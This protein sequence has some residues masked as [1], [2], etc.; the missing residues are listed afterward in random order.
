VTF[1]AEDPDGATDSDDATFTVTAVNDPPQITALSEMVFNE[2]D[3]LV[4]IID[5]LYKYVED[6]DHP[7]SL[8]IITVKAGQNVIAYVD[9]PNVV[10]KAPANWYGADTLEVK[11]SDGELADSVKVAVMVKSINDVPYFTG[12]PDTVSFD[13]ESDTTITM[14]QFAKDVDAN[15]NLSWSFEASATELNIDFDSGLEELTLS[16]PGYVGVVTLRCMVTDDSSTSAVDSFYV[17]ISLPTAIED[18]V[19]IIPLEYNLDQN[20]PNPFNP[21]THIQFGMKKAGDVKI[22]VYN[23]L[24]QKVMTLYD[25]YKDAGYHI[26]KFNASGF[27][28]GLY[29]YRMET[30]E[31]TSIKKMILMK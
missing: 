3:S 26:V 29:F 10:I 31:F 20:Y 17:K 19:G 12:L 30:K 21:L 11:V 9:S 23:V 25:G 27:S 5:T 16:A 6:P 2:D 18:V 24:G 14:S 7:D 1:T 28:S 4:T 13:N 22:E 8:L 15:D